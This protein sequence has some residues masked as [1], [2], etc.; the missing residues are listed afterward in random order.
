MPFHDLRIRAMNGPGYTSPTQAQYTA[1]SV[2]NEHALRDF[3][4]RELETCRRLLEDYEAGRRKIG[5]SD[6]GHSWSDTTPQAPV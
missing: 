1:N 5:V 3:C 2:T 6:D 4:R